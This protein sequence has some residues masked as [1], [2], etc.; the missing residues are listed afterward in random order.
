MEYR[1]S[2]QPTLSDAAQGVPS[3]EPFD[4]EAFGPITPDHL[5]PFARRM[6]EAADLVW[7]QGYR[8]PF[9]RELGNGTLARERF[10]FYL[11]QDYR[12]LKDYAK[13]HALALTKT[14][15]SEIMTFM[16]N[17]QN[18]I[19]NVESKVHRSYMASYGVSEEEM[20]A[21]RQSAFARAYTS[22]ILSIAYGGQLV[23]VLVAVLPCAWVY[24]D[25]GQRLAREFAG[26][27]DSNP[28]KS[29]V[30]MYKTDSFWEGSAWLIEHIERLVEGLSEER[31]REL[32]D[33][34]V[35]GV[36]NEY[37]FWA[38]AYDMHYSWKPE[39]DRG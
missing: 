21:V 22:N 26:T 27:L 32:I 33:I 20:N 17:V 4:A 37:M 10:A 13:V 24:A 7:E 14:M 5:P 12:Y 9:I 28:Y 19:F 36:E 18:G 31:K 30:D 39:W 29:W 23:D 11:L 2:I 25:Y 38:S 6:R 34:F 3:D 8:Q 35:T 1:P 15:D 16:V